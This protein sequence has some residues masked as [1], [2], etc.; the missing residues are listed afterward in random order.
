M[1]VK[2]VGALI[3]ATR[4]FGFGFARAFRFLLTGAREPTWRGALLHIVFVSFKPAFSF[5]LLGLSPFLYFI[6]DL[7]QELFVFLHISPLLVLRFCSNLAEERHRV[8][9]RSQFL[10]MLEFV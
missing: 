8:E 2:V 5:L 1:D 3:F 4:T 6:D 9:A 10:R 7:V